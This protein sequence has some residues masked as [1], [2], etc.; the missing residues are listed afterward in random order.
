MCS[1]FLSCVAALTLMVTVPA[2]EAG[3]QRPAA[4]C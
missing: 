1:R 3:E 4:P 2:A